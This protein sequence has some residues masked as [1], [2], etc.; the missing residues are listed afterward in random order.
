MI[1]PAGQAR[2]KNCKRLRVVG[3]VEI[4]GVMEVGK[5]E[6]ET[7]LSEPRERW[8]IRMKMA[9]ND[10]FHMTH[11]RQWSMAGDA[12]LFK[13]FKRYAS[14]IAA[15]L[16]LSPVH[17]SIKRVTCTKALPPTYHRTN[18]WSERPLPRAFATFNAQ[19]ICKPQTKAYTGRRHH[20]ASCP[21]C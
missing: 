19:F 6:F 17:L 9:I 21:A 4:D 12:T 14:R 16:Y 15:F 8:A 20:K 1:E 3:I 11:I 7:P 10:S 5:S 18:C 2:G 13:W